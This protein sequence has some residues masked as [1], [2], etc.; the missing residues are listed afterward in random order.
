MVGGKRLFCFGIGYT[1]MALIARLRGRGWEIAGTCRS[2]E[3]QAELRA[4]GIAAALFDRAHPLDP[5]L[6]RGTTHLLSSVPPEDTGD[7]VLESCG[8]AIAALRGL[9]WVGYLSTTGV[10]G[11]HQGAWVDE[12]TAPA[13]ATMRGRR[14]LAA[15]ERWATLERQRGLPVHR[16]RLAGIYGPGRNV[17]LQLRA[18]TARLIEKPG[19]VFSR[20]HVADIAMALEAS[21]ARPNPGQVYNLCDDEPAAPA[22]VMTYAAALLGLPLPPGIP[23]SAPEVSE[24][25]RSFYADNKR[26]RATRI[27]RELGLVWRYPTYREGLSALAR[28]GEGATSPV[29]APAAGKAPSPPR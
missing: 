12:A 24:M 25:A 7:P 26:V 18:G 28:A 29:M 6:L 21:M 17:L 22:E 2:T 10:Y 16:F 8:I 1:A 3:R 23:L 27:K 4:R 11:D 14:R 13:P 5:G 20:I 9:A 15:E 19:Q